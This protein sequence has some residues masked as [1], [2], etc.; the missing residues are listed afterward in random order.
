MRNRFD[1]RRQF[2]RTIAI[3][4][5]K[6]DIARRLRR[7]CANLSEGEFDALVQRMAEVDVRYRMRDDWVVVRESR[8]RFSNHMN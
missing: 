8:L 3:D 2:E 4:T 5:A 1:M 6:R 7:I